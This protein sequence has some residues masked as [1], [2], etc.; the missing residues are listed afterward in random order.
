MAETTTIYVTKDADKYGVRK[1]EATRIDAWGYAEVARS[2]ALPGYVRSM[3]VNRRQWYPDL[4]AAIADAEK[5]RA[6]KIASLEKQIATMKALDLSTA[7]E[8]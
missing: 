2:S 3:S 7:V 1:M 5:R 8:G 6:K 4:C